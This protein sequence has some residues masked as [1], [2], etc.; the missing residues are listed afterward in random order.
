MIVEGVAGRSHVWAERTTSGPGG[1]GRGGSVKVILGT[2]R[3]WLAS[4]M[5]G[6]LEGADILLDRAGS[7]EVLLDAAARRDVDA[8]IL[9][10]KLH[11]GGVTEAI[12][13]L[14]DRALPRSVPLLVYTSDVPDQ[15]FQARALDAGAW[16]IVEEPIRS[17]DLLATL[18]RFM[19]LGGRMEHRTAGTRTRR[20]A[21]PGANVLLER[22]PVLEALA[23]REQVGLA[24][25]A[26]GPTYPGSD[27]LTE[28]QRKM[29]A[30][31]CVETLRGSDLCASL[32]SDGDLAVVAY[33]ATKDGARRLAERLAAAA[34]RRSE[35]SRPADALS[36]GIVELPPD[37]LPGDVRSGARPEEE[38]RLLSAAR[39]A[40]Q[41]AR[42]A[43]GGIRFAS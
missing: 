15:H 40:L 18:R 24:I 43:G 23:R 1:T 17:R 36:A 19:E 7:I 5:E 41:K 33:S 14:L 42:G 2:A 8:V 12:R 39:D 27:D 20:G 4:A 30:D 38:A 35:F 29:I 26:V 11:P 34:A 28:R 37:R 9:D 13:A 22:L 31:V 16:G 32:E 25:V 10:A 3:D 21:L 6:V